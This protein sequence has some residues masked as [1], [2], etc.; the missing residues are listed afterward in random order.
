MTWLASYNRFQ[1]DRIVTVLSTF[2]IDRDDINRQLGLLDHALN[3][4]SLPPDAWSDP[5]L[6]EWAAIFDRYLDKPSFDEHDRDRLAIQLGKL[7][8]QVIEVV[9][10]R[11]LA[12]TEL[13][14]HTETA[15]PTDLQE[16]PPMLWRYFDDIEEA[17][18]EDCK[19]AL[20]A[21]LYDLE[22]AVEIA[23][24]YNTREYTEKDWSMIASALEE[25]R[26]LLIEQSQQIWAYNTT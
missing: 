11:M 25:V 15:H 12:S 10:S 17:L 13:H 3:I 26:T 22:D 5:D 9:Y 24:A 8:K 20:R 21:K 7:R 23:G 6:L 1:V 18:N 16:L 19:Q 4:W 14:V 2:Q